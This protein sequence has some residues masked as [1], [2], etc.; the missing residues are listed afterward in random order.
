MKITARAR[1]LVKQR[2]DPEYFRKR[3]EYDRE[4][5]KRRK[6]RDGIWPSSAYYYRNKDDPEFRAKQKQYAAMR[7]QLPHVI[8]QRKKHY[9]EVLSAKFKARRQTDPEYA[10]KRRQSAKDVAARRKADPERYAAFLERKR[11][12]ARNRRKQARERR[13]A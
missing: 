7:N 6:E 5:R 8:A 1:W 9:R 13:R 11:E 10:E 3:A 12:Y 2:Q 4:Y